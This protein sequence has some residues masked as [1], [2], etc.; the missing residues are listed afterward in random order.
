MTTI[1]I[2]SL[3]KS[4]NVYCITM[5]DKPIA[6]IFLADNSIP[7]SILL[8]YSDVDNSIISEFKFPK[9]NLSILR[10]I[11]KDTGK[12]A[13]LHINHDISYVAKFA[14][15]VLGYKVNWLDYDCEQWNNIMIGLNEFSEIKQLKIEIDHPIDIKNDKELSDMIDCGKKAFDIKN[16]RIQKN[17]ETIREKYKEKDNG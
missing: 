12:N 4:K 5:A 16:R 9:N 15:E 1:Q 13:I 3:E 11:C 10:E 2:N 14:R 6:N 17:I 8:N 7:F